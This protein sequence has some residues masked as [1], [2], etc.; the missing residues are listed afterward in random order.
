ML[1]VVLDAGAPGRLESVVR[2][3]ALEQTAAMSF[4]PVFLTDAADVSC[5][6]AAGYACETVPGRQWW[7]DAATG[8]SW[9]VL[10]SAS[11]E[12]AAESYGAER[13]RILGGEAALLSDPASTGRR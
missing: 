9:P 11:I 4:A 1:V 6:L 13:V 8:R 10:V 2:D 7:D 5:V 3:V 12:L